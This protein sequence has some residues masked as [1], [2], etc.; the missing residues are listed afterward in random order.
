MSKLVDM[1]YITCI[2]CPK[3]CQ[4]KVYKNENGDIVAEDYFCKRGEEYAI[5]EY[6]DPKRILT[7][8]MKVKNGILPLIPVRSNIPVPKDRLI[9]CMKVIAMIETG[10]PIKMG[11]ILIPNILDINVDIIASRDLESIS[12]T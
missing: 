4:I 5:Q 10:I 1:K 2:G 12:E 8:T 7:T 9:D 3:G 6:I 11:D